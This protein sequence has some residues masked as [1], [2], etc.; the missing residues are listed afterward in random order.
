MGDDANHCISTELEIHLCK[1]LPPGA[2]ILELGSGAGTARLAEEFTMISIEHDAR[3][4]GKAPSTYI[5]AP[6][7]PFRKPCSVFKRD[8]GWYS[9]EVLREELPKHRYDAILV[10]GPP[11]VWG[12]GGFY[13]WKDLF[14]LDVPIIIDDMH[15]ERET[16]LAVRLSAFLK[17]PYTVHGCWSDRHFAVILP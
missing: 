14:N 8:Q 6:I 16:L 17:R 13:K 1:I 12:R 4:I 15:R 9:R 7:E 10:D 3:F 5:Y 2:T 11:N